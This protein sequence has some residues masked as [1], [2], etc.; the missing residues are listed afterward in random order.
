MSNLMSKITF[1]NG[2]SV[3]TPTAL[4]I[5]G[6]F[7]PAEG[8]ATFATT[9]PIDGRE[10]A[11]IAHA[12]QR[13]VDEAVE[14]ARTAFEE[15]WGLHTTGTVRAQLMHKLAD[16]IEQNAE[17][18]ADLEAIDS[19]KSRTVTLEGDI[20]DSVGCLRYYAGWADKNHGQVS[21]SLCHDRLVLN[22]SSCTNRLSKSTTTRNLPSL[23]TSLSVSAAKCTVFYPSSFHTARSCSRR[24][25]P[26]NYPIMMWAWKV[27]PAL[28]TGNTIV[29]KP[30]ENTLVFPLCIVPCTEVTE[31]LR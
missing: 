12:S 19:G 18:L 30:A 21:D 28:A 9:S 26:W 13:D 17:T 4:F 25:I 22:M 10:L 15:A 11:H 7:R 27:A 5:N 20:V 2:K 29:L 24:S 8:N 3:E 16:L 31:L 14:S 6:Q 1:S 23:G